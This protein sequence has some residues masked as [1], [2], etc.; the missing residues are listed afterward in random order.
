M[1]ELVGKEIKNQKKGEI[2]F[3][4]RCIPHNRLKKKGSSMGN[5]QLG[6]YNK[7]ALFIAI[8]TTP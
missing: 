5:R 1:K 2:I 3:E 6:R 7:V 8:K 4:V